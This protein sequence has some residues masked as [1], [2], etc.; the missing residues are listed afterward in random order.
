MCKFWNNHTYYLRLH[1]M[2]TS[3]SLADEIR[4]EIMITGKLLNEF[5]SLYA[6]MR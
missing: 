6:N 5:S 1:G 2:V 4:I 3:Q